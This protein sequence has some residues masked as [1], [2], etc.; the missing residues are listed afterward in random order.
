MQFEMGQRKLLS[1]AVG[2]TYLLLLLFRKN[3]LIHISIDA[4]VG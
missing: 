3:F 2:K 4:D 1:V